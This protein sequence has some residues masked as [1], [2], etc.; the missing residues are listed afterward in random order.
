MFDEKGI[1]TIDTSG[2]DE[3]TL[4]EQVLEAGAEDMVTE[5]STYEVYTTPNDFPSVHAYFDEKG[6]QYLNAEIAKVPQNTVKI[7]SK[8]VK[9][10]LKLM[11]ALDD[12]DD[13]QKV[14]AN[15]DIDESEMEE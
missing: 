13:V 3:D 7:E 4:M 12:S 6:L 9:T 11:E 8:D 2:I 1:I 10:L 5:D 15:F 14:W